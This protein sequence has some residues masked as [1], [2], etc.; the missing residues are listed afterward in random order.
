MRNSRSSAAADAGR[1]AHDDGLSIR[2][3][4]ALTIE[5]DCR[6]CERHGIVERKAIVKL[7]GA[8]ITLGQLRRRLAIGCDRIGG[9]CPSRF[10]N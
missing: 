5:V 9:D 7:H 6:R 4:K 8:A 3:I 2:Q 10:A 1:L